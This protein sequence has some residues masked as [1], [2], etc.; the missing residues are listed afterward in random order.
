MNAIQLQV[1]PASREDVNAG[2][3]RLTKAARLAIGVKPG[4]TVKVSSASGNDTA[5]ELKVKVGDSAMVGHAVCRLDKAS[6]TAVGITQG[7]SA[8]VSFQPVVGVWVQS[9]CAKT[10]KDFV[11]QLA[12][13]RPDQAWGKSDLK[14]VLRQYDTEQ[15]FLKVVGVEVPA[16]G[17]GDEPKLRPVTGYVFFGY[18]G[19][20]PGCP[21]CSTSRVLQCWNCGK[22]A[23]AHYNDGAVVGGAPP[24]KLDCPWCGFLF[25]WPS[26]DEAVKPPN[27]VKVQP[28]SFTAVGADVKDLKG[29]NGKALD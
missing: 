23:C 21:H 26:S 14:T 7:D 4:D 11:L 28:S 29:A 10:K 12:E 20:Y 1:L 15:K 13:F 22:Y 19:S 5:I 25:V 27:D 6:R 8:K 18:P 17:K 9:K 16:K 2:V 3:I 24:Y